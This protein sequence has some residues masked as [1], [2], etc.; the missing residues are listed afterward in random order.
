MDPLDELMKNMLEKGELTDL[1]GHC[2]FC[3]EEIV[4]EHLMHDPSG[5]GEP[6]KF[7]SADCLYK[8]EHIFDGLEDKKP[9][10]EMLIAQAEAEN[11]TS[12]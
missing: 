5:Q 8:A 10:L 3:G 9:Q 11:E 2:K 12:Q 1:E 4:E 7:C 6:I